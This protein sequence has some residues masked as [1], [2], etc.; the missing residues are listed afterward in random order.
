MK[1]FA[2]LVAFVLLAAGVPAQNADAAHKE[3]AKKEAAAGRDPEALVR[4]AEWARSNG[5]AD[6]AKRILQGV[7]KIAPDN[8]AANKALGNER[9]DGV[10]MTPQQAE[11]ARKRAR[12]A[13]MAAKGLVEVDGVYVEKDKAED[14]RKGI[15]HAGS[16]LVTKEE[17]AEFEKGRV[18]HPV[19]GDFID[20][21]DLEQAKARRFAIGTDG[22]WVEEA[23]ADRHHA[24]LARPWY[25][26]KKQY[27]LQSTLPIAKLESTLEHVERALALVQPLLGF[28]VPK[29]ADRPLIV[30]AADTR[31][32]RQFGNAMGDASSSFGAFLAQD[33]NTIAVPLQGDVRPVLCLWD[34]SWGPYNLP[35]AIGL[36]FAQ[37]LCTEVDTELPNWLLQGIGAYGSRFGSPAT[38]AWFAQRLAKA[39]GV[40]DLGSWLGSFAIN[41]SME[42]DE[43][44]A[45]MT[46]A[47]LVVA[48]CVAGGDAEATRAMQ[49]LTEAFRTQ[50]ASSIGQACKALQNT[51]ATKQ[52]AVADYL[53]KLAKQGG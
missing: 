13:A 39:G 49:G 11:Q 9:V 19:T 12:D 32:Y 7:L 30:I 26:R 29:P 24:D 38:A 14:A 50:K 15:F 5:L 3:L 33:P 53:V 44:D 16:E 8:E 35:H 43:I 47:G 41:G 27:T 2:S 10:W 23:E 36:A 40:K 6:D 48:F 42:F 51:L 37:A 45:A 28:A 46:Q 31:Q 22:R 21:K 20:S 25:V 1:S 4:T 52:A 18:R 34:E 17:F